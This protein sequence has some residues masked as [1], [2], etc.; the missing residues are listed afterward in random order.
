ML[1][2]KWNAIDDVDEPEAC[3]AFECVHTDDQW[4]QIQCTGSYGSFICKS[5]LNI[6]SIFT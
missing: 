1:D 2:I 3:V 5:A 6:G 4:N